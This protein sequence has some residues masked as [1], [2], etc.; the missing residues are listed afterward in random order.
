MQDA[1]VLV[2]EARVERL[3]KDNGAGLLAGAA[4]VIDGTDSIASKLLLNQLSLDLGIPLIHAG[5]VGLGGQLLT[6]LPHRSA[7]LCCLF[8][9]PPSDDD[10]PTCQQAGILG[11]VVG[12]VGLAAAREG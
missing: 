8:P 9:E 1:Q 5:A 2:V 7:C 10:A 11:P 6:I 12:A 4:V 3:G